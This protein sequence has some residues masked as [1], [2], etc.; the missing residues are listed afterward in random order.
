MA[1]PW[2]AQEETGSLRKHSH[3]FSSG[4]AQP[5]QL[6]VSTSETTRRKAPDVGGRQEDPGAQ[7][8]PGHRARIRAPGSRHS[9]PPSWTAEL[10][11]G[12]N[13]ISKL[14]S[15]ERVL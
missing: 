8:C 15:E 11:S 4:R 14:Y 10:R 5:C 12:W 13:L 3:G 7:P 6:L 9:R 1:A 2:G